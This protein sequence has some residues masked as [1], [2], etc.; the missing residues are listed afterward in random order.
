MAAGWHGRFSCKCWID[1]KKPQREHRI[2]AN[3]TLYLLHQVCLL[4]MCVLTLQT[5]AFILLQ[6]RAMQEF[7]FSFQF[8]C[9]LPSDAEWSN[10]YQWGRP[11]CWN[12]GPVWL[13]CVQSRWPESD[14]RRDSE[15]TKQSEGCRSPPRHEEACAG[16]KY[17]LISQASNSLSRL[18]DVWNGWKFKG[19]TEVK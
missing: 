14:R 17:R 4:M 19:K 7:F 5:R 13:A 10:T 16:R 3:F 11:S 12:C 8:V 1:Q 2:N 15:A 6:T 18:L 9:F